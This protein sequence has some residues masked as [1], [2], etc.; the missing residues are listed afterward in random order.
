MGSLILILFVC[1]VT[2]MTMMLVI[3]RGNSRTL[4]LFLLSG[5]YICLMASEVNALVLSL[6][7]LPVPYLT[8]NVTPIVEEVLKT[9]PVLA[10][11][12]LYRP[13]RQQLLEYSLAV[14]IG[15]AVLENAYIL[16][17][18]ADQVTILWA[19]VRGFGAGMMH[20]LCTMMVGFGLS[21]IHLKMKLFMTGTFALM[22][23]AMVYHSIYN[24]IVQSAYSHFGILMPTLTFLVLSFYIKRTEREE[25]AG[26]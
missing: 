26:E 15:F 14:G 25:G 16:A 8:V 22:A 12:C 21:L 7:G 3:F 6:S 19:V 11:T 1:I 4:L 17:G 24:S 2:P 9:V 5:I 10:Y 18:S 20:G 13:K 23:L